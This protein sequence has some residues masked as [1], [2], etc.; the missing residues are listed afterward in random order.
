MEPGAWRRVFPLSLFLALSL[1]VAPSA[2]TVCDKS[3]PVS[4]EEISTTGPLITDTA[5]PQAKSTALIY[6]P[7]FLE[8]TVGK[9]NSD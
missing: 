1:T 2:E 9:F 3:G 7:V 5:I 8:F 6:V 4:G